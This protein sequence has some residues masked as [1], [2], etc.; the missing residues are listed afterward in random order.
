[1]RVPRGSSGVG[2]GHAPVEAASGGLGGLGEGGAEHDAVGAADDGL[3]D[4][5]ASAES[6][7]GDDADVAPGAAEVV[8]AGGGAFEGCG[9]LGDAD[10]SYLA[11]GAGRAGPDADEDAV[12]AGL[13]EFLGHL[14]GDAVADDYGDFQG[15]DELGEDEAP[16][17][18]GH[19][20]GGGDGGLDDDDVGPRLRR[21]RGTCAWCS[22][23]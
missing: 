1:M 15:V 21:R 11:G 14:V 5:A 3:A 18:A 12:D 19:V 17:A 7:V 23:G 22:G 13:H 20:A 16:V 9:D 10:A 4:V 2:V 8:L 6:A